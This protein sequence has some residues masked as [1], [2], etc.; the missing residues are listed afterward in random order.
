MAAPADAI[1]SFASAFPLAILGLVLLLLRPQRA[2]QVFFALFAI[3]WAAQIFFANLGRLDGD[4]FRHHL[5]LLISASLLPVASLF[6][7]HFAMLVRRRRGDMWVSA[8]FAALALVSTI[9]IAW[10]PDLVV[11]AVTVSN[12]IPVPEW[13]PLLYPLFQGPIRLAL[14]VAIGA[15][16]LEYRRAKTGTPRRRIRGVLLALALYSSYDT[17]RLLVAYLFRADR[18]AVFS[19]SSIIT[20]GGLTDLAFILF[21]F[22][23]TAYL[24]GLAAHLYLRP[25]VPE[26]PDA[27]LIIAF[28]FPAAV[29]IAEQVLGQF[30]IPLETLGFWRF[31]AVGVVVY[32][33]ANY[34]LFDLDVHLKRFAGPVVASLLVLFGIPVMLALAAGE[35][36]AGPFTVALLPQVIG[37]GG[38]IVFQDR[39]KNALFPGVQDTPDYV[40]QRRLDIYRVA[41][42]DRLQ[43]GGTLDDPELK[44]L[45]L[46]NG[47]S[48]QEH[49][50]LGWMIASDQRKPA[51]PAEDR[52]DVGETVLERYRLERLIGRGTYGRTFVAYDLKTRMPVAVKTVSLAKH[53][54]AA[55][56]LLL[57]EARLAASLDHPNVID[58]LDVAELPGR[59]VVVMEYADNGNLERHL[60]KKGRL[61]LAEGVRFLRELLSAL[62]AVHAKDIVH[63]NLKPRNILI[64][65]DDSVRLSDFG[66]AHTVAVEE[67]AT[68]A[69]GS[70]LDLPYQSPER[71]EGDQALPQ[72]DLFVA[73]VLFHE[74]L[75]LRNPHRITGGDDRRIRQAIIEEAPHLRLDDQPEWVAAFV[76]QALEKDPQDRF[77]SA[78]EMRLELERRAGL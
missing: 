43:R 40:H 15:V 76:R 64:E 7:V 12:G 8:F 67:A 65:A 68:D 21:L 29:G 41:V 25:P 62:E 3:A 55:A 63:L 56:R 28:L 27:P 78:R 58:I 16:Y 46:K 74:V 71:L 61:D 24:V 42:E 26:G 18:S 54:G 36:G 66:A 70:L 23:G 2:P 11:V 30:G 49:A 6:L 31:M 33:L 4:P 51:A 37:V 52:F 13:G 9:V 48:D 20:A 17:V 57:R 59:V 75:T 53:D 50:I 34:H 39:I 60:E 10:R 22:A 5:F 1:L 44:E 19:S 72:S 32:T 73:G 77:E 35:V 14:Y 45:R 38:V 69:A 47:V